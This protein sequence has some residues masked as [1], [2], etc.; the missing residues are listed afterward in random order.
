MENAP[1]FSRF[2]TPFS[3]PLKPIMVRLQYVEKDTGLQTGYATVLCDLDGR[4]TISDR[5]DVG[6]PGG[7]PGEATD[8]TPAAP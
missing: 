4:C 2:S 6:L 5:V 1:T 7:K 8:T 3:A